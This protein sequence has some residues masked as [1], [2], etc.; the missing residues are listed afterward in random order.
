M[1]HLHDQNH[2]G[3]LEFEISELPNF[4]ILLRYQ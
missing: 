2:L 4:D 3:P 1:Y